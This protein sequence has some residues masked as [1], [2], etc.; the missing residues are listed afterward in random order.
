M[1]KESLR[2]DGARPRRG[3]SSFSPSSE[4]GHTAGRLEVHRRNEYGRSL[5]RLQ[6]HSEKDCHG[7]TDTAPSQWHPRGVGLV[8]LGRGGRGE[9]GE[10]RTNEENQVT[11]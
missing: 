6:L 4:Q 9:Q 5:P 2:Q 1:R 8:G 10:A 3:G 11:P 7:A